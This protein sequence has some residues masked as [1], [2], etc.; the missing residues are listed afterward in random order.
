[1]AQL[2][3]K[4]PDAEYRAQA[5][6]EAVETAAKAVIRSES[7]HLL[8]QAQELFTRLVALRASLRWLIKGEII[9]DEPREE[10]RLRA[11][12]PMLR[13]YSPT[14]SFLNGAQTNYADDNHPAALA[15]WAAFERL[16]QDANARL[17][18]ELDAPPSSAA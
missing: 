8:T 10:G 9:D 12:D 13:S 5:A 18:I 11:N 1:L 3:A 16:M 6:R 15:W 4:L 17:P 2:E 7:T 14:V